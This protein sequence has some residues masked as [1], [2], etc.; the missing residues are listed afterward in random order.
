MNCAEFTKVRVG[1]NID[2]Q[3]NDNSEQ[4][5]ISWSFS[6]DRLYDFSIADLKCGTPYDLY[7]TSRMINRIAWLMNQTPKIPWALRLK[8]F[9]GVMG[10]F[11]IDNAETQAP[12]IWLGGVD[13]ANNIVPSGGLVFVDGL[14][15]WESIQILP[16]ELNVPSMNNNCTHRAI[17]AQEPSAFEATTSQLVCFQNGAVVHGDNGQVTYNINVQQW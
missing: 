8:Q 15:L 10:Y 4:E 7:G 2:F 1:I 3:P 5:A 12:P 16:I 17:E 13:F 6:A 11:P 9:N 14:W